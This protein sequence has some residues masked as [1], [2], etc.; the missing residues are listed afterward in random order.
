MLDRFLI[1][2]LKHLVTILSKDE[3]PRGEVNEHNYIVALSKIHQNPAISQYF[4]EREEH[5]IH[6][7]MELYITGKVE[8]TDRFA[9]QL[10]ELRALR[11]RAK[12]CYTIKRKE[13]ESVVNKPHR[14]LLRR[15]H[16]PST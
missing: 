4:D 14:K 13:N 6:K 11:L 2:L 12:A 8:L 3:S 5:L 16:S 9:G 1:F 7:G 10:F 15:R